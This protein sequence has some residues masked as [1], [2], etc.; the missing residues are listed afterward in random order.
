MNRSVK[1]SG[2]RRD[3]GAAHAPRVRRDPELFTDVFIKGG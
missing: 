1:S 3:A 2:S